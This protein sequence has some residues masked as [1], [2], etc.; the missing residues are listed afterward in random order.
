[1]TSKPVYQLSA[2][3]ILLLAFT[4][5]L[6]AVGASALLFKLS[7]IWQKSDG[8]GVSFAETAPNGISDPSL[9]SDEQNSIEVYRTISPES[10]SSTRPHTR[11]IGGATYKK[12][13]E[14]VA[15]R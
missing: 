6:I 7:D 14:T 10:R 8:S 3:Q 13:A 12:G 1:M 11:R 2:R 4:T 5:A 9:V 15:V